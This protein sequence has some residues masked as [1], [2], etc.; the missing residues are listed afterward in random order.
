MKPKR[1]VGRPKAEPT[2]V[3]RIR[4]LVPDYKDLMDSGGVDL[5]KVLAGLYLENASML[6]HEPSATPLTNLKL[7][8][9]WNDARSKNPQSIDD[10]A[11]EFARLVE[12]SHEI[13]R[14][15]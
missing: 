15:G 4:L 9:L 7:Q 14:K 10:A 13:K 3:I 1:P 12:A 8:R 11:F 5:V 2:K 6:T